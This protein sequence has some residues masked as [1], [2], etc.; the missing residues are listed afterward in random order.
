MVE[1]VDPAADLQ[2]HRLDFASAGLPSDP[3]GQHAMRRPVCPVHPS[4]ADSPVD[5]AVYESDSDNELMDAMQTGGLT[6]LCFNEVPGSTYGK[7]AMTPIQEIIGLMLS[8]GNMVINDE[9]T[10]FD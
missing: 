4:A 10:R 1:P 6:P 9:W 7:A 2:P 5:F 8:P 3:V